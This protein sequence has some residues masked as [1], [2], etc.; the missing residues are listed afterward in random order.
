MNPDR[1]YRPPWR[2]A[3]IV[4]WAIPLLVISILVVLQPTKR[5]VMPVY[6]D[7]VTDWQAG[8]NL[9]RGPN[10]HYL[11]HFAILFLPFHAFPAPWGDVVWRLL[12]GGLLAWAFWRLLQLWPSSDNCRR[13]FW[14]SAIGF[15]LCL[16]GM[17]NGQ[18]NVIFGALLAHAAVSLCRQGWWTALVL[19]FLAMMIKPLAIVMLLLA[20]VVYRPVL[21]RAVVGA[22]AFALFPFFFGPP[23]YVLAQWQA[24]LSHLRDVSLVTEHRF[25]DLNGLFRTLGTPL[26]GRVSQLVRLA[27]GALTLAFWW[28]GAARV[29][30]P[31]RG[32]FLL[33]LAT[34]YL[35]VFNPMTEL[36]S[37]VILAPVLAVLALHYFDQ[38]SRR[39]VGAVLIGVILSMGLLPEIV[40]PWDP[41]FA[42]WWFPI[43][44]LVFIGLVIRDIFTRPAPVV[45][46]S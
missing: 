21:W 41:H 9:Y 25:A 12:S 19:L 20:G 44:G 46:A 27:A 13:F 40:R 28:R 23:H 26:N 35:M 38:P 15:A 42:L 33:A 30:E 43:M 32:V 2:L 31:W 14:A 36:N 7:A 34:T 29:G 6:H 17:R 5:T 3:G 10:Y 24:S 1:P 16:P 18:A 39:T 37:Y 45:P 4:L 22:A 8:L 11:P